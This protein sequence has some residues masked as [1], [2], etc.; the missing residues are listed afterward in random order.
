MMEDTL[1]MIERYVC[2]F[3]AR[4]TERGSV[5]AAGSGLAALSGSSPVPLLI[6]FSDPKNCWHPS[7]MSSVRYHYGR[8]NNVLARA[9]RSP[10]ADQGRSPVAGSP[11]RAA[12]RNAT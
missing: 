11:A 1:A 12:V 5:D 9:P 10:L 8:Y 2:N 7:E 6:L 3:A 4:R